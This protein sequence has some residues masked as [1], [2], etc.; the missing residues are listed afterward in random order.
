MFPL[1]QGL[2][3]KISSLRS[4]SCLTPI[5]ISCL[6]ITC[7]DMILFFKKEIETMNYGDLQ[8]AL[9]IL[10]QVVSETQN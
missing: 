5:Q 6:A 1:F 3:L 2:L 7:H 9:V 10:F 8:A 4:R